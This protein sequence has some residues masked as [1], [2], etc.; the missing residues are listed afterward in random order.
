[1]IFD[2]IQHKPGT[3]FESPPQPPQD[4]LDRLAKIGLATVSAAL[5][6]SLARETLLDAHTLPRVSGTGNVVGTAVTVWNAQSSTRMLLPMFD[7]LRPGDII[8]VKGADNESANW[9]EVAST[10]AMSRGAVGVIIDGATRD[11]DRCKELGFSIWTKRVYVGQGFRHHYGYVN[12]PVVVGGSQIA[13]G[14]IVMAGDDGI[15]SFPPSLLELAVTRGEAKEASEEPVLEAARRGEIAA[16]LKELFGASHPEDNM[17]PLFEQGI[18]R[19]G[20]LWTDVAD[21]PPVSS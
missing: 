9:G 10:N 21:Q 3:V 1:M 18:T 5:S 17:S 7:L 19:P 13:P 12:I 15:F 14:D 16:E 2:P 4:L 11:V 6:G 20:V 8:V